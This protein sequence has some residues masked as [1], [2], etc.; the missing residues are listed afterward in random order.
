[1]VAEYGPSDERLG[2][3]V[4][5][6][7]DGRAEHIAR[8]ISRHGRALDGSVSLNRVPLRQRRAAGARSPFFGWTQAQIVPFETQEAEQRSHDDG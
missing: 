1:M 2:E 6:A 7:A 3:L 4:A 8:R 5:F